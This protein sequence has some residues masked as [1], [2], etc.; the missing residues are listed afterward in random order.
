MGLGMKLI[1]KSMSSI[2]ALF[3]LDVMVC[4]PINPN[5]WV[6]ETGGSEVQGHP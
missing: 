6:I 3:K 4:I 2:P 1:L 5:T